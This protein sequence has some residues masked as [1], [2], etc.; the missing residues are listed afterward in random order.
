MI[1]NK[2]GVEKK[3]VE[4]ACKRNEILRGLAPM[5]NLMFIM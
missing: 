5:T 2:L 3:S 1:K 4:L